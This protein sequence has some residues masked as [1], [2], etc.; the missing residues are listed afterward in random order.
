MKRKYKDKTFIVYSIVVNG[1]T[2]YIGHTNNL[3]RREIQHNSRYKTGEI[4]ELYN[5]LREM[6]YTDRIELN[7]IKTFDTKVDAKR[8]EMLEILKNYFSKFTLYQNI[9][10]IM[11]GGRKV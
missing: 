3:H 8:W 9:P 5:K 11:D 10:I 2:M 1:I 6:N 4:K 7:L